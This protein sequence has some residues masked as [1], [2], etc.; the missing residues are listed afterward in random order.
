MKMAAKFSFDAVR[1]YLA[2]PRVPLFT[3]ILV[4]VLGV[5]LSTT[6]LLTWHVMTSNAK[7][8]QEMAVKMG[9]L[10]GDHVRLETDHFS[11]PV[12]QLRDTLAS[13]PSAA[14]SPTGLDHPLL[15]SFFNAL[16][17]TPQLYSLYLASGD[18][19]F[20][21]A[22]SFKGRPTLV[23][24]FSA[25][26]ETVFAVRTIHATDGVRTEEWRFFNQDRQ[27]IGG[28]PP[29]PASYDP[30]GRPW[31]QGAMTTPDG[32][33]TE[34][35]AFASLRNLGVSVSRKIAGTSSQ[36]LG[37]DVALDTL[38]EF[39]A[40]QSVGGAGLVYLA[41][42]GGRLIAYPDQG[43]LVRE[44]GGPDGG[45][46][47]ATAEIKDLNDPLALAVQESF[48]DSGPQPMDAR[49]LVVQ[50]VDYMAQII[51][52]SLF[53][54][55]DSFVAVAVPSSDFI[56]P[57][58]KA[59]R[60]GLLMVALLIVAAV[61][62]MVLATR[63]MARPLKLLT[64]EA[65]RISEMELD[66]NPAI[67]SRI[68]EVD[69]L[70]RS[71]SM[72]KLN[73]Q[74]FGR[75]LPRSLIRHLQGGLQPTLGGQRREITL[76]FTD[77]EDFTVFS[78]R[79]APEELMQTMSDYFQGV[80]KAILES[81]GTIDKFIGDSVMAFWNAPSA[82]DGHV[83][84]AC[85]AALRVQLSTATFNE[86][87]R[88]DGLPPLNTRIGI[89]TG[90]AVVGNIGTDD[91]M[92]YTALGAVVNLTSRLEGLNKYYGTAILV[93]RRVRDAA[94]ASFLFRS[95]DV[96]APKGVADAQATFE[97]LGAKPKSDYRDV[98]VSSEMLGYC[99]RWERA[100]TMYRSKQWDGAFAAFSALS[101]ARPDDA[102]AKRYVRRVERLLASGE[103]NDWKPS[104]HLTEK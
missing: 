74:I 14:I 59:Q 94:H 72:M 3:A 47:L 22:I 90:E 46:K 71:M 45:H 1:R 7:A 104:I 26:S 93:S 38:S 24:D 78:E 64:E 57:V 44:V 97:L 19:G 103:A 87:R 33:R 79:M 30:R 56:G 60:E 89:H 32:F 62:V 52:I 66:D 15:P 31:Y 68:S 99:S 76:I 88:R 55:T 21:Q 41:S 6:G 36:V 8:A 17:S 100:M 58:E 18:G 5:T 101:A 53:G 2:A 86:V 39:T 96:V 85:A 65:V 35:Y 11:Q 69:T 98:A 82:E 16:E 77:V 92:D 102:L 84:Q 12:I 75:Y 95:A 23:R 83:L 49:K 27:P 63:A 9:A 40:K 29:V 34:P 73:F 54:S 20:Y 50:G 28:R 61:P 67:C 43:K 25:P 48:A 10:V 13:V 42:A 4:T 91:R 51:P 81:N 37:L 80:S 70:C